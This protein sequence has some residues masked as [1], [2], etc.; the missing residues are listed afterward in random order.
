M[1]SNQ[2]RRR[3]MRFAMLRQEL[4]ELP[5]ARMCIRCGESIPCGSRCFFAKE[6]GREFF[7]TVCNRCAEALL[8]LGIPLENAL[9][10]GKIGI[11]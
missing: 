1:N 9:T 6:E 5:A 4:C 11:L 7:Q 3:R 2:K 10:V 8:S